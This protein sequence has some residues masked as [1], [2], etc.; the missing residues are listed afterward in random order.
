MQESF[1]NFRIPGD[2]FLSEEIVAATPEVGNRSPCLHYDECTGCNV[3]GAQI[4]FIKTIKPAACN[5]SQIS[6]S[7]SQP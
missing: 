3:P 7:R 4:I 1:K 5:I 2:D 6:G